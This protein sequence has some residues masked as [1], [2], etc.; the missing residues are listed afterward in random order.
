MS[1]FI[2]WKC[3]TCG[4]PYVEGQA[5]YSIATSEERKTVRHWDCHV[6]FE[7]QMKSLRD[8]LNRVR[9]KLDILGD[10]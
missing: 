10:E 5:L 9:R 1:D 4:K 8:D 3:D 2:G 6:P 7:D